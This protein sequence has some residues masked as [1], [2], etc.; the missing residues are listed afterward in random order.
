M[1]KDQSRQAE[2]YV[3]TPGV[4][5]A[6]F[7]ESSFA[8]EMRDKIAALHSHF[9]RDD[10][11]FLRYEE[12]CQLQLVTSGADMSPNQY[13]HVCT[14]LE[15]DPGRGLTLDALRLTY[16]ADGTSADSD[17][18]KVFGAGGVPRKHEEKTDEGEDGVLEVGENGVDISS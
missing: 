10:D 16:A 14:M 9:D 1:S 15:C 11:G 6:I 13:R 2:E 18:A 8:E 3:A 5:E 4:G 12:L 7:S 17:Y